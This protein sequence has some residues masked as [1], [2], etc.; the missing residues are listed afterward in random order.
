M[1][2]EHD[3]IREDLDRSCAADWIPWEKLHGKT[4]LITGA[5]GLIGAALTKTVLWYSLANDVRVRVLASVRD[6]SKAERV[7]SEALSAG[8]PLSLVVGDVTALDAVGGPVDFVVHGASVTSSRDFVMR[9]VE[10]IRT[11]L[12]GT[13]RVLEL[14]RTKR[15]E[16]AVY[17]SSMEVYGAPDGSRRITES[18]FDP[19]DPMQVRSSYPESKRMAE[20]LCGA[21]ASEFGISAKVLRLT[22][23]FGPGVAAD[24]GRVFAEFARCAVEG[25]DIVLRTTGES[26]RSY[27][28]T[29]DAVTAILTVLLRGESGQ[30][31][32]AANESSYC[33]VRE[34]AELV[35]VTCSNGQIEVRLE[36]QDPALFGYAP[37]MK[38]DLD[39]TK[40]RRLGWQPT[41][42]LAEMYRRMIATQ[43]QPTLERALR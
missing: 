2:Q 21:Y 42:S 20:C 8:A 26:E 1:W 32:H 24:D 43:Q 6:R 30:A 7:F 34:M 28:Y 13:E 16:S 17:L 33:S 39:T 25:R 37:P 3:V 27:L 14:A 41:V 31:Y 4:L 9:P 10:T 40:I 36:P 18:D 11:A 12:S 19:L 23:T 5:T 38:M 22:Q 15:V 29:A 35:A